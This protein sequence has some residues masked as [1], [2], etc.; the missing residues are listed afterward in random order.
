M[1]LTYL[2]RTVNAWFVR[3]VYQRDGLDE[4]LASWCV[5]TGRFA[6]IFWLTAIAVT[7]T[8]GVLWVFMVLGHAL[9]SYLERQMEYDADR[10][11][12]R[13]VG[14]RVAEEMAQRILLLSIVREGAFS[15]VGGSLSRGKLVDDFAALL[16]AGADQIPAPIRRKVQRAMNKEKTRLF[17]THPRWQARLAE[18]RAENAPGIF[19]FNQPATILFTDYEKLA[20]RVLGHLYREGLAELG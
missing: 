10:Y 12:A 13:L 20:R 14:S 18:I 9:S 8:R 2:V 4:S 15:F 17:D 5:E 7:R 1:R 19:H 16:V 11:T 6:P 3:A